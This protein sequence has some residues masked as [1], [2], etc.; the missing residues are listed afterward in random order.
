M[1]I[2]KS[3]YLLPT[4]LRMDFLPPVS[5]EGIDCKKLKEKVFQTDAGEIYGG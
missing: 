4:R 1:P 2:H 5:P 3:F